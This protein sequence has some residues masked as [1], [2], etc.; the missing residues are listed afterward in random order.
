VGSPGLV[1]GL[2]GWSPSPVRALMGPA[3]PFL[4]SPLLIF[5][6]RSHDGAGTG[7]IQIHHREHFSRSSRRPSI[8]GHEVFL[9]EL[10]SMALMR[11]SKRPYG[12]EWPVIL[13]AKGRRSKVSQN[14]HRPGETKLSNH[15]R[16]RIGMFAR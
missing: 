8:H 9:R 5:F 3:P 6:L 13:Q 16:Q 4:R 1:D 12:G 7:Q 15:Q 11:I 2:S 14:P 10:V